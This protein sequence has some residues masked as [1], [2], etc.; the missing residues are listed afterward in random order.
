MAL[1]DIQIKALKPRAK[2][3]K[4]TDRDALYID[5][6]TSGTKT[7][8]FQ[9]WLNGKRE[10]VTL[11]T[12]PAIGLADARRLRDVHARIA[13]QLASVRACDHPPAC[14]TTIS[15]PSLALHG[16]ALQ[17]DRVHTQA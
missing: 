14:R 17:F 6:L 15:L 12:Y 10:K 7:W 3:Y 11:G 2:P 1:T 13:S 16:V 9:Y 4:V 8:R 5:V